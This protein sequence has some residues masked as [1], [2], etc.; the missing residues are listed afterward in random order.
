MLTWEDGDPTTNAF[1]YIE[2]EELLDAPRVQYLSPQ[3]VDMLCLA[4]GTYA[5]AGLTA[6]NW[7]AFTL[8][9]AGRVDEILTGAIKAVDEEIRM[10]TGAGLSPAVVLTDPPRNSTIPS[11]NSDWHVRLQI[12]FARFL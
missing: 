8:V 12:K 3:F 9:F 6:E 5:E 7:K 11:G 10:L 1:Q 4:E 2:A